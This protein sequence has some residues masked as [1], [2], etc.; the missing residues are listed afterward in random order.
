MKDLIDAAID[1][2]N[3]TFFTS[4]VDGITNN[5]IKVLKDLNSANNETENSLKRIAD[6]LPNLTNL[7]NEALLHAS[8]IRNRVRYFFNSYLCLMYMCNINYVYC[9]YFSLQADSLR[10]L[11]ERENNNTR[12]QDAYSAASA[13]SS[14]VQE[15][16]N[17]KKASDEAEAAVANITNIVSGLIAI[18]SDV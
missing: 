2:N 1:I 9:F 13:Y 8:N 17:A 6:V 15:I 12:T 3:A 18:Y 5:T 4:I 7:T 11:A 10:A 14:I 16:S